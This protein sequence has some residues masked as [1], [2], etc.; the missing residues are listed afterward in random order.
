MRLINKDNDLINNFFF[1]SL[2][3]VLAVLCI[4]HLIFLS[5]LFIYILYLLIKVKNRYV[6]IMILIV[7]LL[8]LF[9]F[10]LKNIRYNNINEIDGKYLIY[11]IKRYTNYNRIL[12]KE[13]FDNIYVYTKKKL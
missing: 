12:V 5:L 4:Y 10:I 6:N 7:V 13:G 11:D 3:L 9:H 8:F 2:F 1:V